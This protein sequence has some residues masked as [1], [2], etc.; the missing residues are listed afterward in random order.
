MKKLLGKIIPV[1]VALFLLGICG[2]VTDSLGFEF[3]SILGLLCIMFIILPG[4]YY[5]KKLIMRLLLVAKIKNFK[6]GDKYE[7][8]MKDDK[9]HGEGEYFFADGSSYK[10]EFKDN[11]FHGKGVYTF[12]DKSTKEGLWKDDE[13]VK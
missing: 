9:M 2:M 3:E 1:I 8:E 6:N 7:G 12:P 5:S 10:G 11:L 4:Y 13:F